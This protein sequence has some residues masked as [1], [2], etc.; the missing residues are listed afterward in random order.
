[1]GTA[2]L[3]PLSIPC[4]MV[5]MTYGE[6]GGSSRPSICV[7]RFR[8]TAEAKGRMADEANVIAAL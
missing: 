1:V 2:S 8:T 4:Q 6:N 7:V 5:D 3:S